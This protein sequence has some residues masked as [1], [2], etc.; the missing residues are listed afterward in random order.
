MGTFSSSP[1]GS[2]SI[3]RRLKSLTASG[4]KYSR[5]SA[6]EDEI[7]RVLRLH[8]SEWILE[9][10]N[11]KNE[12]IVFLMRLVRRADEQLFGVNPCGR[13]WSEFPVP[14]KFSRPPKKFPEDLDTRH[15][16]SPI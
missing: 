6:V 12:T 1:A 3:L 4:K 7:Q 15:A 9:A 11:L 2:K 16:A 13:R 14:P 8:Q 5:A 10:P